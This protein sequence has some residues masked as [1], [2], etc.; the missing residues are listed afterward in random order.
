MTE[1]EF[2]AKCH[3]ALEHYRQTVPPKERFRQMVADGIINE[4]GRGP[5]HQG[6]A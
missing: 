5:G 4:K 3:E 1:R 2:I 6:R